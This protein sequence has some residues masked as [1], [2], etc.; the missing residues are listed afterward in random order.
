MATME[1]G[2]RRERVNGRVRGQRKPEP[3]DE[4]ARCRT[5]EECTRSTGRCVCPGTRRM[6]AG[7]E[8]LQAK[9]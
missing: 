5:A 8:Y 2:G 6:A 1:R 7:R 4:C 3:V 9:F